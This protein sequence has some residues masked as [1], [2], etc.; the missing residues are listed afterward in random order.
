MI[1][2]LTT[3][4]NYIEEV[5]EKLVS[6]FLNQ[7]AH[8]TFD[9]YENGRENGYTVTDGV[10]RVCFSEYRNTDQTVLYLGLC[11]DFSNSGYVPSEKVYK[12]KVFFDYGTVDQVVEAVVFFFKQ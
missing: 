7:K 4:R 12:N 1:T 11:G 2:N 8:Y 10:K 3:D 6:T 9:T 5:K